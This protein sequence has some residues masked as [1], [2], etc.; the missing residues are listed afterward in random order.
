MFSESKAASSHDAGPLAEEEKC[1]VAQLLSLLDQ[2][3]I[4]FKS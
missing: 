4:I 1:G 2:E 3:K